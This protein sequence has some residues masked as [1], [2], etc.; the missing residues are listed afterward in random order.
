MEKTLLIVAA[1]ASDGCAGATLDA[2]VAGKF[3]LN[4]A[5][6]I[7]AITAQNTKGVACVSPADAKTVRRQIDSAFSDLDI[8]GVKVGMLWNAEI[9]RGVANALAD[10]GA[11]NVVFDPVMSAQSDGKRMM[12]KD[13]LNAF[14]T[15][16]AV[17]DLVTPNLDEAQA[18]SGVKVRDQES[19]CRS[20]WKIMET[21]A[22]AVMLKSYP[23]GKNALADIVITDEGLAMFKKKRL[24]TSTHGGGCLLSTAIAA[25]MALGDELVD[26]VAAAEAYV[27]KAIEGARKVGSGIRCVAP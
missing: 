10:W 23:L 26:A 19:A 3:S 24:A 14:R 12:E 6:A 5:C 20:A 1:S 2:Q 16:A 4:P 15:V 11:L 13:A 18:L 7:T 27:E 25:R 17:S 9:A 22:Q 8:A 21:G